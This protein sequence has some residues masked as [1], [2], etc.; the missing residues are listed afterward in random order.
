MLFPIALNK[1]MEKKYPRLFDE[2]QAIDV[3]DRSLYLFK[4]YVPNKDHN[5]LLALTT[6]RM[7]KVIF[8]FNA[9][10]TKEI[11]SITKPPEELL[12][13]SELKHLP[14]SSFALKT[15]VEFSFLDPKNDEVV[16]SL[17]GNAFV[18]LDKEYLYTVWEKSNGEYVSACIDLFLPISLNHFYN[19]NVE[20][21][22]YLS[23]YSLKE[24]AQLKRLCGV[25]SF[26]ELTE[27]TQHH[28][29]RMRVRFGDRMPV[30]FN[31]AIGAA[32]LKEAIISRLINIILYLV[33]ENAD[34][35]NA[36]EKLKAGAMAGVLMDKALSHRKAEKDQQDDDLHVSKT[37][38]RS[39]IR[40]FRGS[41]VL[42]VGYRIAAK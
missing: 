18:W 28:N 36:A 33:C 22:L 8:N 1:R 19:D 7:N 26:H 16:E 3:K 27:I 6:W 40:E 42:D 5:A 24:I 29:T 20:E 14:Y 2:L 25:T 15:N 17:T 21:Y 12:P 34:I 35:E 9:E 31:K 23:A 39:I 10:A 4:K 32:N 38:A 30:V 37:E 13:V 11:T 41:T